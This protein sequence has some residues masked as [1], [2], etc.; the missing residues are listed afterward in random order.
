MSENGTLRTRKPQLR[1]S[2][3]RLDEMIDGLATAIPA[4]V[5]DSAREVLGAVLPEVIRAAIDRAVGELARTLAAGA[6]PAPAVAP[7]SPSVPAARPATWADRLGDGLRSA[8]AAARSRLRRARSASR[9]LIG[10]AASVLRASPR[11]AVGAVV[12]GAA[13]G[14]GGYLVGPV[15]SAV[16][17]GVGAGMLGLSVVWLAPFAG[18]LFPVAHDT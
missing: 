16:V 17:A 7:P 18:L 15:F 14:V 9:R 10:L 5:A 13:V 1:D 11:V 3:V 12:V 4:A 2:I 6:P 8:C